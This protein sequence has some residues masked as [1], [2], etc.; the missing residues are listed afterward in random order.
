[1]IADSHRDRLSGTC[2]VLTGASGFLGR[3]LLRELPAGTKV[4]A[5]YYSDD[6]FPTWA[7]TCRAEIEPVR[8]DLRTT[9]LDVPKVDWALLLA[10]RVKAEDSLRDPLG[11]LHGI[12][13]VTLN[14]IE[15]L[16]SEQ[17]V[18]LSTG[19]VYDGLEGELSPARAL[20]PKLP[21]SI[22]KLA[23]ELLFESQA[24][25]PY[26]NLRFFGAYGPG[27]PRFKVI[28]RMVESFASGATS[29]TLRGDGRNRLDPMYITDAAHA[30]IAFLLEPARSGTLDLCQGES[31]SIGDF[32]HQAYRMTHPDPEAAPLRLKLT[33]E[34]HE[35]ILGAPSPAE[36]EAVVAVSRRS[37]AD[38]LRDYGRIVRPIRNGEAANTLLPYANPC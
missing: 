38:G 12:A 36:Q 7:S 3:A 25:S 11:A 31:L 19:S 22:A 2:G 8:V 37:I 35:S 29:F 15:R 10:A 17:I 18:H 27:E 23:G 14:S 1:M 9:Q 21:Y 34:T 5:T 26:W 32:A 24:R 6:R 16:C 33:G 20:R 28:R 30:L 13:D 4:Y